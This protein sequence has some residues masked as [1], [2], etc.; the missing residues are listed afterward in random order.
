MAIW[1]RVTTE[2]GSA[3]AFCVVTRKRVVRYMLVKSYIIPLIFSGVRYLALQRLLE[4][5]CGNQGAFLGLDFREY[6]S[7]ALL[8]PVSVP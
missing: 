4:R 8:R 2:I 7:D 3:A 1:R 6:L 5:I